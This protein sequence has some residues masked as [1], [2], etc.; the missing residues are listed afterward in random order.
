MS[1]ITPCLKARSVTT[2]V[3]PRLALG[4]AFG[5]QAKDLPLPLPN[6]SCRRSFVDPPWQPEVQHLKASR[7]L[8]YPSSALYAIIADIE[9]YSHFLPYCLESRVSRWSSPDHNGD[10]WP[11]EASL[12]VGWGGF[13]E[14]FVS[15]VYCVPGRVVEAVSGQARPTIRE[16]DLPHYA[17]ATSFP[18]ISAATSTSNTLYKHLLTTWTLRPF[19]YKPPP[20][21]GTTPQEGRALTPATEQT[22]VDLAIDFQFVNPVYAALS[23]AVAPRIAGVMIDAFETRAAALLGGGL[24]PAK[25]PSALEGVVEHGKTQ[26]S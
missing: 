10:K 9:S 11:A 26:K 14:Q 1:L 16:K 3:R 18:S 19:P 15:G 21:D 8:P 24:D 13:E 2:A 7:T 6:S 17:S 23:K 4:T 20:S 12:R 25:V 5:H 22:E